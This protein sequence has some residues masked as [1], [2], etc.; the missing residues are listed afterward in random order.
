MSSIISIRV[1]SEIK[2]E[3]DKL[4]GEINWSE[5]IRE[6]IKKKIEEYKKKNA[7]QEVVTFIQTLPT[8]PKGTAQKLLRENRDS[9]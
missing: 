4:K 1:P 7:L 3:M 2:R 6:F 9:H 8:A 5:E